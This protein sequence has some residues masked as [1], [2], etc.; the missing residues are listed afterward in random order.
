MFGV[1]N[2][3]YNNLGALLFL[4]TLI[5]VIRY[6]WITLGL[7]NPESKSF[8][9]YI[10]YLEND[11]FTSVYKKYLEAFFLKPITQLIKDEKE[12]SAFEKSNFKKRF[13]TFPWTPKSFEFCLNISLV[14]PLLSFLIL[15]L[16]FGNT[17][18]T[19]LEFFGKVEFSQRLIILFIILFVFFAMKKSYDAKNKKRW[20]AILCMGLL[21]AIL[22]FIFSATIKPDMLFLIITILF[23]V[24][25]LLSAPIISA[26]SHTGRVSSPI[27]MS[28]VIVLLMNEAFV[29]P[30]RDIL[31][32]E[33]FNE[34]DT[35]KVLLFFL[36]MGSVV[37]FLL[38]KV[39]SKFLKYG[40]QEKNSLTKKSY[41]WLSYISSSLIILYSMVYFFYPSAFA[42]YIL[43][44]FGLLPI[45][46]AFFDWLSL[47]LTRGL[48][49]AIILNKL[50]TKLVFFLLLFDV[51]FAV[52]FMALMSIAALLSLV[53]IDNVIIKSGNFAI[54]NILQLLEELH[55]DP[56][57]SKH[58]WLYFMFLTSL[59]P[60]IVHFL[61]S[62]GAVIQW[63]SGNLP[64][65]KWRK[66][67]VR[68]L[69]HDEQ[70]KVLA[71]VYITAVPI[72]GFL[73]PLL[74]L[75]LII[76][77]ISN[78]GHEIFYFI[79]N[80]VSFIVLLFV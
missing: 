65:K 11:K 75:Y 10:K 46:N 36:L 4:I 48:I 79:L 43:V 16:I 38:R 35:A 19:N 3:T 52:L 31:G 44:I 53:L 30:I 47:G 74:L 72:I 59:I 68:E 77:G 56:M 62:S 27:S 39:I 15:S 1:L 29:H 76:I 41:T 73:A 71:A 23:A 18:I 54:L 7:K 49:G 60:T 78:Y 45:I 37:V 80:I 28:I 21:F 70:N 34:F 63:V 42:Y 8:K 40:L 25:I 22:Y 50:T 24:S 32:A 64:V 5:I 6:W 51:F 20:Y 14:Y 58:Y 69:N 26:I 12:Y 66:W 57:S 2:F 17:S 67:A 33:S 13:G 9:R 55:N 61:V